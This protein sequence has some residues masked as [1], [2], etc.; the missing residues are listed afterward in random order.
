MLNHKKDFDTI[1]MKSKRSFS[2]VSQKEMKD[3]REEIKSRKTL[4]QQS[5]IEEITPSFVPV[6]VAGD[7]TIKRRGSTGALMNMT[8]TS[9]IMLQDWR[10]KS[11]LKRFADDLQQ[12]EQN[13]KAKVAEH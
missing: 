5:I 7:H 11:A 13:L 8:S 1:T 6:L 10:K 9:S 2:R 12:R 4:K 3:I